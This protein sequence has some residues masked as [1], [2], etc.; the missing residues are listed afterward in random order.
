MMRRVVAAEPHDAL[1]LKGANSLLA[2]QHQMANAK[3]LAKR[4]IRVFN[5]LASDM[6]E[7]GHSRRQ[8]RTPIFRVSPHRLPQPIQE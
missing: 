7:V 5:D 4:L 1:N 8:I 2:G 3:P 6:R